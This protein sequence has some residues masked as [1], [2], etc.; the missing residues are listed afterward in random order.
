MPKTPIDYSKSCIYKICCKDTSITD[1]YVG[2][3]TNFTKRKCNH[4]S[5]C[6]NENAKHYHYN[7]Y[8][9]IRD[10]GGWDNWDIVLVEKVNVN[11]GNELRKEERKW[12]EQL[13]ATLN[14][15]IPTRTKSEYEKEY[16]EN[17]KE[18]ILEYQKEYHEN[19]KEKISEKGKKWREDNKEKLKQ[20]Y[21]N[22]KDKIKKR[23]KEYYENNKDKIKEYHKD[24]YENNK[25]K[26]KEQ[27][28]E[29]VNCPICNSVITKEYLKK[30]QKSKKCLKS[31]NK[32]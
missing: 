11:D 15:K 27:R 29:K 1:I 18:K 3:T 12:I 8:Q 32:I 9:F 31:Q 30:H 25:D 16:R 2:S 13:N 20:Y 19:N 4:K 6:N 21:E 22:N 28:K 14:K 10:N 24:W 5:Y 23:D 7:V 26:I 17:N